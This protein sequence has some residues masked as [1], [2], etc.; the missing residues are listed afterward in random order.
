MERLVVAGNPF[1]SCRNCRTPVALRDDIVSKNFLAKSRTAYLFSNAMN[2]VLGQNEDR[3]LMS[4]I[5]TIANIYC[6]RC[7]EDLG[8]KYIRAYDARHKYK[9]GKFVLEKAQILKEY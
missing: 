3:Q 4:G 6:S 8:W 9:E 5:F 7:G 2:V 1:Y